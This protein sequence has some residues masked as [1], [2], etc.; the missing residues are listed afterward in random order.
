M[1]VVSVVSAYQVKCKCQTDNTFTLYNSEFLFV[2]VWESIPS[3]FMCYKELQITTLAYQIP[4]RKHTYRK[5]RNTNKI[6]YEFSAKKNI[7][8]NSI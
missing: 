7:N 6:D 5:K 3:L 2:S 8:F 1:C 4:Y